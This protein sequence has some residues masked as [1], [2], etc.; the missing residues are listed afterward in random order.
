MSPDGRPP[1]IP[2]GPGNVPR[3]GG[4]AWA[5]PGSGHDM[6][7]RDRTPLVDFP[8]ALGDGCTAHA[9]RIGAP[10]AGCR[11]GADTLRE[12]A[13]VEHLPHQARR[14]RDIRI[15]PLLP[16]PVRIIAVVQ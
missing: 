12:L 13:I 3:S 15:G 10:D 8:Q 4:E 7:S 2:C 5:T 9:L 11:R 1:V 6:R 14:M 16:L